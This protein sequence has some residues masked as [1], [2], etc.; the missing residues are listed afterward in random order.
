MMDG[1]WFASNLTSVIAAPHVHSS[2]PRW[3]LNNHTSPP[4]VMNQKCEQERLQIVC[5]P[6]QIMAMSP[7]ATA[8]ANITS[9]HNHECHRLQSHSPTSLRHPTAV[10]NHVDLTA[11]TTCLRPYI[12][13][14]PHPLLASLHPSLEFPDDPSVRSLPP[15]VPCNS[16]APY[17]SSNRCYTTSHET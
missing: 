13:G 11:T 4:Q 9:L 15:V 7:T 14:L 17:T 3:S 10:P 16:G 8:M 5:P 12:Y 2:F 1:P 6:H